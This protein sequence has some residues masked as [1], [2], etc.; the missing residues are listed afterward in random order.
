MINAI[1]HSQQLISLRDQFVEAGYEL[2]F[3]GGCVRDSL[4]GITP[5]DIDLATSATPEEQIDIYKKNNIRYIATGLQHGTITVVLD[6]TYE[7]TSLREDVSTNGRHAEVSYT[8]DILTDLARR[9]LT[10]NAMALTFGGD[11]IDPYNGKSDLEEGIVR[12]V[13]IPEERIKEDYLRILRFFRF[14]ARFGYVSIDSKTRQAILLA[15]KG[16]KKISVERI[17]DEIKKIIIGPSAS[18]TLSIMSDL[19]VLNSIDFPTYWLPSIS[20]AKER[21]VADPASIMGFYL[22]TT[23]SVDSLADKWKWSNIERSRAIFIATNIR[24]NMTRTMLKR[25]LVDGIDPDWVLDLS[26]LTRS[27]DSDWILSWEVPTFPLTGDDL[28][29]KGFIRG[30]KLGE[31]LKS[32]RERWI[33]SDYSLTKEELLG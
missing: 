10:I 23:S 19:G 7:I 33:A 5:K 30:P 4:Y 17:W 13:G 18:K 27:H 3:V 20:T 31:E 22:A 24:H 28:I 1:T 6:D 21:H 16:L 9:D 12:F 25:M 26:K 29:A 2:W 14:Y 32:L 15:V 8:R 11:L